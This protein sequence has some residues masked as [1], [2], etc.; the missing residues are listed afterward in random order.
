MSCIQM[1]DSN[2]HTLYNSTFQMALNVLPLETKGK[3][4]FDSGFI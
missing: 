4:H 2:Q 1:K 3:Y